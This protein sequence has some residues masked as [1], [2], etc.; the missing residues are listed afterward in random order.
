MKLLAL[1]ATLSLTTSLPAL[2]AY[3]AAP[4]VNVGFE[5][6][7]MSFG[8]WPPVTVGI[9]YPTDAAPKPE[10]LGGWTQRVATSARVAPGQHPLVVMSHGTG[11][12]FAG[13]YDTALALAHAGFVVASLTH[14]GDNY[15]DQ[16]RATDIP[17]RVAAMSRLIDYMLDEWTQHGSVDPERV[18]IFG[19]SAGGLTALVASGG[20]PELSTFSGHCREHPDNADCTIVAAAGIEFDKLATRYPRSAWK[21]DSR[22]RAAVIA[23]PALGFAFLRHGLENATIPIQLWRAADDSVLP[24]PEYADAVRR[25]L[26]TPP[27]YHVVPDAGHY[28]F[29]APCDSA[30]AEELPELCTSAPGFDRR[31]FHE[32]F[33]RAVVAFFRKTLE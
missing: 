11:G 20:V 15:Q 17:L 2:P 31:K 23:G 6:V 14:P 32:R 18:G 29:L 5:R 9:W 4:P 8:E 21:H 26:P 28:D 30:M 7:A 10:R 33:D 12:W 27:E 25:A 19:F 3:R 1:I 22:I 24:Y 16:S 13:H